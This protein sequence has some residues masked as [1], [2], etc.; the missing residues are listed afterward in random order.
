[1]ISLGYLYLVVVLMF[2]IVLSVAIAH[3]GSRWRGH[4][5][6][7]RW[8]LRWAVPAMMLIICVGQRCA[9]CPDN[10]DDIER[11]EYLAY[12]AHLHLTEPNSFLRR[13]R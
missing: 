10:S 8:H 3:P 2:E 12:G 7:L 6:D 4:A 9:P 1:M 11:P 5:A 13:R